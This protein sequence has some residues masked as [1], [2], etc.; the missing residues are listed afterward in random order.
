MSSTELVERSGRRAAW[1][2]LVD[3]VVRHRAAYAVVLGFIMAVLVGATLHGDSLLIYVMEYAARIERVFTLVACAFIAMACFRAL[4]HGRGGSPISIVIQSLRGSFISRRAVQFVYACVLFA[5][6]MGAFLYCKML[7]PVIQ[8]FAW[9]ATFAEWDRVL[10]FGND[11]WRVLHPVLGNTWTTFFLD[12]VYSS[13]VPA[14]FLFWAGTLASPRVPAELR[15]Q[16]WLAT[17][18]SWILI[19]VVMAAMFSSA[20]PCYFD[21]FVPGTP[22]PYAEL[23]RYIAGVEARHHLS[24]TTAKMFLM[25]VYTGRVDL[26]GG[27][28]AMPSMHNAQAVLFVVAAYRLSR[29]FGRAMLVYSILIFLGSI[30]LGWHYAVDGIVGGLAALAIWGACGALL[31]QGRRSALA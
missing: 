4:V 24:S 1:T 9:D 27:I 30:H 2:W 8:P 14:V 26:P 19:G 25:D 17:G 18:V 5:L 13:W 23:E 11:A 3:D 7:I 31:R 10:F 29:R 12:V 15:S 20:G 6:F 21:T 22:S 28:S 16:Y